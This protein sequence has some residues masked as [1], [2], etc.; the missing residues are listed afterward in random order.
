LP[1]SVPHKRLN[2]N[3]EPPQ[4]RSKSP[5]H[6]A[7]AGLI[8]LGPDP[9]LG[10][11]PAGQHGSTFRPR[12]WKALYDSRA[13]R[14]FVWIDLGPSAHGAPRRRCRGVL[15]GVD[16]AHLVS[17]RAD[18]AK[19]GRQS[20]AFR[21]PAPLTHVASGLGRIPCQITLQVDPVGGLGQPLPRQGLL[22][23]PASGC[24][25][26]LHRSHGKSCRAC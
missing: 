24:R 2:F 21:Q 14:G 19:C 15:D 18:P 1:H 3:P 11:F 23:A 4:T 10:H 7:N 6:P 26:S 25:P 20:R 17:D 5:L 13:M 9:R 12:Q 8:G 22:P 16:V